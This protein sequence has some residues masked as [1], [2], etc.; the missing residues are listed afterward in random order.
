[1]SQSHRSSLAKRRFRFGFT[2][3][4]LLV[5]IAI[6][7]L[8]I[9]LLLP[10]VQQAREAARRSQCANNIKQMALA[11]L[12]HE[13]AKKFLPTGG[14]GH[15]WIGDPD[16][17]LGA[18]QP[19]GWAY[20]ILFFMEGQANIMQASGQGD[21]VVN[22]PQRLAAQLLVVSGPSAVQPMFYCPSRRPAA[23]YPGSVGM[24]VGQPT[25]T[26]VAKMDYAAN[27]GTIGFDFWNSKGCAWATLASGGGTYI[28]CNGG[29]LLNDNNTPNYGPS[30][31]TISSYAATLP[32]LSNYW[33]IPPCNTPINGFPR[34]PGTKNVV[35]AA[36]TQFTG[37]VWY[38]SQVSLRQISDG[39]SKVYLFG[40]KYMDSLN[41]TTSDDDSADGSMYLGMAQSNIRMGASGGVWS[42]TD[43]SLGGTLAAEFEVAATLTQHKI[44]PMQ[45]APIWPAMQSTPGRV[46]VGTFNYDGFNGIRF[47]SA[48]AGA[49][50]IS[51]CD[52]SVHS[53]SYEI[54]SGVHAMLSD[55]QDGNSIDPGQYVS[56]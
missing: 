8:L 4:E 28:S 43:A 7:G 42:P 53:I 22:S 9:A 2:L 29:N 31:F 41:Y 17:G 21:G 6:I 16:A 54:D 47:G 39:A 23:L 14:W 20:S 46:P 5:V 52:G 34:C 3:V 51:F 32:S 55:R 37:V 18:G 35:A 48:H 40:E 56:N 1:M 27:G 11:A 33:Y 24:N 15:D 44:P 49:F 19:G 12:N 50:N 30:P 45:D 36:N 38:R 10:A 25:P 26:M 13:S